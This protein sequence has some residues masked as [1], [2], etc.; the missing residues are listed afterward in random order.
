MSLTMQEAKDSMFEVY[1]TVAIANNL[2]TLWP[3]LPNAPPKE[4]TPWARIMLRHQNGDQASLSGDIGQRCWVMNG[5]LI[6]QLFTPFGEGVVDSYDLAQQLLGA[7]RGV[8]S[9]VWYTNPRVREV[10]R[11]GAFAQTNFFVDFQYRQI[12]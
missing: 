4:E 5:L 3:D 10:G 8:N 2:K 7:Y 6:V 12:Q 9:A 1:N 11:D